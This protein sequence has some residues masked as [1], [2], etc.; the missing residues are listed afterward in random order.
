[1]KLAKDIVAAAEKKYGNVH[2]EDGTLSLDLIMADAEEWQSIIAAKLEL[3]KKA[4]QELLS[5]DG[6]PGAVWDAQRYDIARERA[7][8]ILALLSENSSDT[9]AKKGR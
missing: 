7:L 2:Y 4:L 6:G 1:M 3:V 8:V 5:F 9:Q